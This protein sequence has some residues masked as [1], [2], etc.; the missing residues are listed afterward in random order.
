MNKSKTSQLKKTM[1]DIYT[2]IAAINATV[3]RTTKF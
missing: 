1:S 3:K 2:I